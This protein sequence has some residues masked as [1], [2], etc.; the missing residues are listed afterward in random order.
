MSKGGDAL[1]TFNEHCL[2]DCGLVLGK[3]NRI[4]TM[5]RVSAKTLSTLMFIDNCLSSFPL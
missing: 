1:M 2:A 3:G 5:V 4:V